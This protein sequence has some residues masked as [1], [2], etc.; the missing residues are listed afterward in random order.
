[1]NAS[2]PWNGPTAPRIGPNAINQVATA[3]RQ[4]MGALRTRQIFM[5]AGLLHRLDRPPRHMVDEC[6]VIDLHRALR[7]TLG[8]S[9]AQSVAEEAGYATARYLL[10]RRIPRPVRWLLRCLPARP[11]AIILLVAI[12]RHAWTFAGSGRFGVEPGYPVVLTLQDN[13]MCR[14]LSAETPSCVYYAATFEHLFRVLVHRAARVTETE[15][16]STGAPNCSFEIRW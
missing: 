8:V 16:E 10:A 2:A 11:S 14:G 6:E 15:C 5:R 9:Q 7:D 13:P 12:R 1:M 3:L 4:Q